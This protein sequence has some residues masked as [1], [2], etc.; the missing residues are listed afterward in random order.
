MSS[1]AHGSRSSKRDDAETLVVGIDLSSTKFAAVASAGG[2]YKCHVKTRYKT[3][4]ELKGHLLSFLDQLGVAEYTNRR[5]YIEE[6]VIARG[7]SRVTIQQAYA[8]GAVRLTL[9]ESDWSVS[10]V[11]VGTWKKQVVGNGRADK[12]AISGWLRANDG[13]LYERLAGDQDLIDAACIG[14]Y[15]AGVVRAARILDE[16]GS[17]LGA[18]TPVLLPARRRRKTEG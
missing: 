11:N 13:W 6:A 8:M 2:T 7:G 16:G 17:M 4:T 15:G 5:A 14:R 10:L 12:A 3:Y 1:S 9:E 18:D